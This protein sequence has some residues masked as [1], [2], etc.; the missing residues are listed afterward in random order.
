MACSSLLFLT[1]SL[2]LPE[3]CLFLTVESCKE[4]VISTSVSKYSYCLKFLWAAH[5]FLCE[6]QGE[7][8]LLLVWDNKCTGRSIALLILFSYPNLCPHPLF[9][10]FNSSFAPCSIFKQSSLPKIISSFNSFAYLMTFIM[11]VG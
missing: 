6:L 10:Y 8:I 7:V 11:L 3:V 4:I 1:E 2:S 9:F 5:A